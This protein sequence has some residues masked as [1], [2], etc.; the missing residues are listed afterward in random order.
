MSSYRTL[1]EIGKALVA[2]T[3]LNKLLPLL[4]DN[5]IE[6]THA[7]RGMITVLG[8]D[9]ELLF[10]TARHLDKKDITQ[11]E[12]EI[13]KTII[14]SVLQSGQYT[15]KKNALEDPLV[16]PS[17][18]IGRLRLLSVAC[19]PLRDGADSFGVIYIDNRDLTAIFDEETGK[20]LNEFAELIAAA[21]KEALKQ[22]KREAEAAEKDVKLQ[23]QSER[24]RQLET[25]LA[26]IEGFDEIKGLKSLA[27]LEVVNQIAKVANTNSSVLII[28]ETGTGK[29][30]V[31]RELHRKSGRSEQPFIALNCAALPEEL[32]FSELFGHVKGAFTGAVADKPGY[33]ET[34]EG[35][36]IFLDEIA[37]ATLKFQTQLLRVLESGVFNRLGQPEKILKADV[38]ILSAAGPYLRELIE[39]GEFYRDLYYRLEHFVIRI[40]PLRERREDQPELAQHFLRHFAALHMKPVHVFSREAR[41]L[42]LRHDWPGNVRELRNAVNRAVILA[43][44]DTIRPEDF[45]LPNLPD[46]EKTAIP[47]QWNYHLLK[48]QNIAGFDKEF[49]PKILRETKGRV[50]KAAELAGMHKR[51]FIQKLKLYKINWKDYA[52]GA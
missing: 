25:L 33:F 35:G 52:Q 1:F 26:K 37:K 15:V 40:P 36:T 41:E 34:A 23:R 16:P 18:S 29:E 3:D 51:N 22:R 38:R 27:M 19:A 28:G 20:L 42:L 30:L 11:P 24:R 10:E 4:M 6:Q 49:F 9:G 45:D 21:V 12:F 7:Q 48:Q 2:E 46:L 32:L 8:E 50:T 17:E 47:P 14:Q 44:D 39:K 13:S 31:A 43:E 5:I